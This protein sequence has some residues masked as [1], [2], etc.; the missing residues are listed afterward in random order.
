MVDVAV[1]AVDAAPADDAPA[2]SSVADDNATTG[3][4]AADGSGAAVVDA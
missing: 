1:V 3:A 4:V 2:N